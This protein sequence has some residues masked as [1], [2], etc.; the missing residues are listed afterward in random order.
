MAKGKNKVFFNK[1]V[2]YQM[3]DGKKVNI[4]SLEEGLNLQARC[5]G[6]DCCNN[7]ITLP[8]N[9]AGGTDTFPGYFQFVNIDGTIKL[10]L[11]VDLGNGYITK[12]VT[13]S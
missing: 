2:A 6:I 11:T 8:V 1:G 5:C 4:D 13:L 7:V 10:R 3:K 9:D 12:E